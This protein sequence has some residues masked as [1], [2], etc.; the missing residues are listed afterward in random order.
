MDKNS[1]LWVVFFVFVFFLLIYGNAR[2]GS[3]KELKYYGVE[4]VVGDLNNVVANE[5]K[6]VFYSLPGK[7]IDGS[8]GISDKES[9]KVKILKE[10]DVVQWLEIKE[11]EFN[12]NAN[13]VYDVNF[14]LNIPY[15]ARYGNYSLKLRIE[16]V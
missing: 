3:I 10:G 16:L 13:Q 6:I 12:L 2:L 9:K 5:D 15:E 1:L 7:T 11:N 14:V 8:I 4:I